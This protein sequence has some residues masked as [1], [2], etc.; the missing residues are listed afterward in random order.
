MTKSLEEEII[1]DLKKKGYNNFFYDEN[2][3]TK[4]KKIIDL[5]AQ[6]DHDKYF[7]YF[8]CYGDELDTTIQ[9]IYN[10]YDNNVFK[11]FLYLSD[12]YNV[13]IDYTDDSNY[14]ITRVSDNCDVGVHLLFL[15]KEKY[16]CLADKML[17]LEI[18]K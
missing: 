12:N 8:F 10:N 11:S 5:K 2:F 1:D 15:I 7:H 13:L 18:F 16:L 14:Y 17:T 6:G 9:K 3:S 4:L